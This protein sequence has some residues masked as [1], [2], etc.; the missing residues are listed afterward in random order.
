M[1][2]DIMADCI[3]YAQHVSAWKS[4]RALAARDTACCGIGATVTYLDMSRRAVASGVPM[5]RRIYP[6]FLFYDASGRGNDLNN[7]A[8]WCGYGD[9][10][11]SSDLQDYVAR[12]LKGKPGANAMGGGAD[13]THQ[14]L[15]NIRQNN[16]DLG[17]LNHYFWRDFIPVHD[18]QN[19]LLVDDKG[20]RPEL[21]RILA[22][23]DIAVELLSEFTGK[24]NLDMDAP[25]WTLDQEDYKKLES[26]VA[27]ISTLAETDITLERSSRVVYCYYRAEIGMGLVVAK[28][29]SYSQECYPINFMTGYFDE[30][31]G[32]YYGL[33]RPL[34]FIQDALNNVMDDLIEYSRTA[35][36]GGKVYISGAGDEIK[37]IKQHKANE[38]D[39]TPLPVGAVVTAKELSST[40]QVLLATAQ[41]LLDLL[42]R[43]VGVGQEFLGIITSG[44][45]TDSLYG[46]VVKQ[47]FA[48][49]EDF[50]NSAVGYSQR[51]GI[52]FRD[53]MLG[54]ARA[55]EGRILPVLS[56]NHKGDKYI[57]LTKENMAREYVIRIS[58][59]PITED[60]KNEMVKILLQLAPHFGVGVAPLIADNLH[61]DQQ[62]KEKLLAAITPKPQ[63][64]NPMDQAM[65]EANI[66]LINAQAAK[67]ESDAM[68]GQAK[69]DSED[70][71]IQSEIERN[72]ASA[73]K[74]RAD[75]G[76]VAMD[77]VY[78]WRNSP[79][80]QGM[81]P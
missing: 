7:S 60:E 1:Q 38:D 2:S 65:V 6:G 35:A 37:L 53:I 16:V 48:V 72:V 25:Y 59:R 21:A 80:P 39:V 56:P 31:M 43:A 5:C 32:I 22:T 4:N 67:L 66:R 81:R 79:Q 9:P 54:I 11:R 70:E 17:M 41:M 33:M 63:P 40:P 45:M 51:Q 46:K 20:Q 42:P 77:T 71:R 34:S 78:P 44:T 13:Y 52:L 30:A 62:Q 57:R 69:L 47:S 10:M 23:D 3:D 28:A 74:S 61:I 18:V 8:N 49:L 68:A 24:M 64:P 15:A 36:T 75:A 27:D 76:Q 73:M 58:E 50:G 19:P 55:E 26:L 29:K 14:F 12:K